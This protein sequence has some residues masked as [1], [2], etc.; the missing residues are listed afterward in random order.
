MIWII[1]G[2]YEAGYYHYLLRQAQKERNDLLYLQMHH[3]LD[4]L[5]NKVNPHF[6]FNSLNTLSYLVYEDSAKAETFVEELST[7][8]R[9]MLRNNDERMTTLS[10]EY[11]FIESYNLLLKIRFGEGL[12]ITVSVDPALMQHQLPPLSLQ[13]LVENAV[14]HN[15]ISTEC[16]LNVSICTEADMLVVKNNLQRKQQVLPTEKAGLN[17]LISRY[18]QEGKDG[19]ETI[20]TETGFIVRL[21]LLLPS[22]MA[23]EET[24][25]KTE[26]WI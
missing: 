24:N 22:P 14:K 18:R 4:D 16:P 10:R 23:V 7:V 11:A 3:R 17:Y 19:P 25:L 2:M 9:Y 13:V 26:Q 6:L 12:Q 21:P 8:Y 5:K 15:T 1:A 20:E